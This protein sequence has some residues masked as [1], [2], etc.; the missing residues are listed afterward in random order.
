[1]EIYLNGN[2]QTVPDQCSV[3]E[4]LAHLGFA[5]KPMLVERNLQALLPAE[6]ACTQLAAG[7]RIECIQIVAGG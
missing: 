1:M 4:L 2:L 7:D 6:H 5:G 3:T